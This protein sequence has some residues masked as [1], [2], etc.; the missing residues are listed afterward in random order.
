MI[1]KAQKTERLTYALALEDIQQVTDSQDFTS[2]IAVIAVIFR[3]R[4][5]EG[6]TSFLNTPEFQ[7]RDLRKNPFH[8]ILKPR[9]LFFRLDWTVGIISVAA[10][11]G[12][13]SDAPAGRDQHALNVAS[14]K[15]RRERV[16]RRLNV[17]SSRFQRSFLPAPNVNWV[18]FKVSF[19]PLF[20]GF[21]T[22]LI[23]TRD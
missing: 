18:V 15:I 16:N 19:K 20:N 17:K 6:H 10:A 22:H 14:L 9:R 12:Q 2:H 5:T 8:Q 1:V 3:V 23:L 7:E 13:A 21:Y 11:P 4:I